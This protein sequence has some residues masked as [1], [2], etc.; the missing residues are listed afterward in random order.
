MVLGFIRDQRAT[1]ER[2]AGIQAD[3]FKKLD[4]LLLK[5]SDRSVVP[6]SVLDE[7][8]GLKFEI[9]EKMITTSAVYTHREYPTLT[10]ESTPQRD[11]GELEPIKKILPNPNGWNVQRIVYHIDDKGEEN[12][13]EIYRG[14][15]KS[16]FTPKDS[17]PNK[18]WGLMEDLS[19]NFDMVENAFSSVTP[20]A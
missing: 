10:I 12:R 13:I 14:D 5:K 6:A 3:I 16:T 2:R 1:E 15:V 4:D 18:Y 7:K 19:N 11:L 8:S 9:A 20:Q 17:D